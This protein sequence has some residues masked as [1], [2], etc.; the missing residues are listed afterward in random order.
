MVRCELFGLFG[1][2]GGPLNGEEEPDGERNGGEHPRQRQPL[3]LSAPAQPLSGEVAPARSRATTPMNTSS[4]KMASRVTISLE[5]GGDADAE[6]I[7]RHESRRRR[8]DPF[9]SSAGNCTL[10]RPDGHGDGRRRGEFDQGG[11]N[12]R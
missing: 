2:H 1:R 11:E 12:Q 4:S 7:E 3:K 6:N 8:S 5:G 9:G 10:G